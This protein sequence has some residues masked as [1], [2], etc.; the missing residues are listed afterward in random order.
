MHV[1][2][3]QRT[4]VDK[5]YRGGWWLNCMNPIKEISA[6]LRDSSFKEARGR[7]TQEKSH[8]EKGNQRQKGQEEFLYEFEE[9]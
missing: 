5:E 1:N 9:N 2:F 3:K 8:A 4:S 7:I 6:K